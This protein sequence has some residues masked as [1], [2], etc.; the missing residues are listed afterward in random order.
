M[1]R[2]PR[3]DDAPAHAVP[4]LGEDPGQGEQRGEPGD[5]VRDFHGAGII[6]GPAR[7]VAKAPRFCYNFRPMKAG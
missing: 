4:V 6:A 5:C 3:D 2:E 1:Q 7:I